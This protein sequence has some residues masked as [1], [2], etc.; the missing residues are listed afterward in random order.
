MYHTVPQIHRGTFL[1]Q[2]HN[3]HKST[4]AYRE[5]YAQSRG[6]GVRISRICLSLG[7]WL[8]RV[9]EVGCTGLQWGL[10]ATRL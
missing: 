1:L 10:L 9:G 2:T 7:S 5:V 4:Q 3:A 6:S 8:G